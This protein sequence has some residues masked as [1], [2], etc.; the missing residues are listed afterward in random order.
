MLGQVLKP[1]DESQR[2]NIFHTRRLISD[3]LCS[4][5]VDEGSFANVASTRVVDKIG[6]PTFSH[7][8]PY[9]LQWLSEEGEIIVNKQ[10]LVAFSIGKYKDEVL[11]DIVPMEATYILLGRPSQYDRKTLHDGL[12][13][14]ISFTFHGHKII[15]KS[16][17]PKEVHEDQFKMKEKRERKR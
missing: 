5:I 7:A 4:L 10:V 3:K 9:K 16:L 1:F 17:T 2:E 6:L 12:T 8:K 13:N 15:L 14:K 11:C